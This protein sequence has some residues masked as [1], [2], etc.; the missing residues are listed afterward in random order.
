[1]T[2]IQKPNKIFLIT[3]AGYIISSLTS[4]NLHNFGYSI[5]LLGGS[6]WSYLEI[7]SGVNW[8]RKLLG[9]F[10]LLIIFWNIFTRL[11]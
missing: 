9:V 1:M 4:G 2:I 10:V 7:I 11:S 6:I 8:F 5:F 3:L